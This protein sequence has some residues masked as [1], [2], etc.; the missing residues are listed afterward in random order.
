MGNEKTMPTHIV[1]VGGIVENEKGEILLVHDANH[2]WC[3]PGG[4]VEAGENLQEALRR[5]IWEES[6]AGAE[7]GRLF[8][9][10]SNT[11]TYPGHSG[12]RII[13][14]KVMP[15]FICQYKGGSLCGS[16]ETRDPCWVPRDQV[17]PRLSKPVYRERFQAYLAFDGTPVSSYM[18]PSRNF[19]CI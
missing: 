7:V 1:A 13:P 2:G 5:E 10:S 12:V 9:V 15:D 17:L 3:F 4:Q 18:K 16:D 11:K 19:N 6:G 14:T 8:C